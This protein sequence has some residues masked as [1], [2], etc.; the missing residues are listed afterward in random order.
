MLAGAAS[1]DEGWTV[2]TAPY[3]WLTSITGSATVRGN[4][5]KVEADFS[6]T[7]AELDSLAALMA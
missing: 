2:R 1:A 7:V 3:G 5:I 6:D 4:E